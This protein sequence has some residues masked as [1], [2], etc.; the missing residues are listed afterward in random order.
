MVL[1]YVTALVHA[2]LLHS[3]YL[4][5]FVVFAINRSLRRRYWA[6]LVSRLLV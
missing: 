5:L 3:A 4:L 1:L 6:V 2:D